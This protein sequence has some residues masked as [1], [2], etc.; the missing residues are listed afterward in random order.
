MD[1]W[2]KIGSLMDRPNFSGEFISWLALS[3]APLVDDSKLPVLPM[4]SSELEETG[5][6]GGGGK[7]TPKSDATS[8][9]GQNFSADD[10]DSIPDGCCL[11]A[12][13]MLTLMFAQNELTLLR[14]F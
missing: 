14:W 6:V 9:V 3:R 8:D 12:L 1:S 4:L 10:S 7:A 5:E 2:L 11:V 13:L